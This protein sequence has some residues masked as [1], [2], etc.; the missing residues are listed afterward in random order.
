MADRHHFEKLLNRHNLTTVRRISMKLGMKTR[1][2]PL[3]P[4]VTDK[5]L[6][7]DGGRPMPAN[8]S[9]VDIL[10]VTQQGTESVLCGYRW[11][12]I[13]AQPGEYD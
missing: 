9:E 8:M 10:K 1:F 4:I 2:D 12:C 3:E 11:G 13:L 7:Q 6:N 5:N